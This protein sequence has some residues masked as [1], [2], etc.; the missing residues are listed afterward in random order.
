M[1]VE[2][3]AVETI[4]GFLMEEEFLALNSIAVNHCKGQNIV[5]VEIGAFCGKSTVAIALGLKKRNDGSRLYSIDWHQGSPEHQA[6]DKNFNTLETFRKN[7]RDFEVEP[8][9]KEVI[10]RSELV[11]DN[12]PRKVDVLWID[13]QHEYDAVKQDFLLYEKKLNDGGLLI[14]HDAYKVDLWTGPFK[15]VKEDILLNRQD[16]ALA[17]ICETII[18]LRKKPNSVSKIDIDILSYL[19]YERYKHSKTFKVV[20]KALNKYIRSKYKLRFK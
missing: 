3:K 14:F 13:G 9:V 8:Y 19:N 18:G 10:G 2:Q 7:L 6:N 17:F 12:V 15:L 16:Y 1:K 5:V 4:S 20:D 11:M